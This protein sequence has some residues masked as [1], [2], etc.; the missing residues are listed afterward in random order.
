[1]RSLPN[2]REPVI[3]VA[4]A[5][6]AGIG[7]AISA[8]AAGAR[9][10][11]IEPHGAPG[12]MSHAAN[13]HTICGLY[14]P[15]RKEKPEFANT[16]VPVEMTSRLLDN[17]AALPPVSMGGLWVL[18]IRPA[19]FSA[20]AMDWLAGHAGLDCLWRTRVIG[21]MC[22]DGRIEALHLR[23]A[24]GVE[25]ELPVSVVVDATGDAHVTAFAG[26]AT[27]C[28][29]SE[30]LQRP[31]FVVGFEGME[32]G[33]MA[34]DG[35]LRLAALL[36]EGVREGA[37]PS[38]ALG[39]AFRAG[40]EPG[41]IWCTIDLSGDDESGPWD[42]LRAGALDRLAAGG[43]AL[44]ATM[45]GFLSDRLGT[46][47]TARHWPIQPGVRES[48]CL[49]GRV[50]LTGRDV[51]EGNQFADAVAEIA[52]PMELRET[53]RGPVLKFPLEGRSA[54]IPG[55]ALRSRD[56][57]N[58][59]AAGRCLSCDHDAQAAIRVIGMGLATGQ[60][61]GRAAARLAEHPDE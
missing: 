22:R 20:V 53:T 23:G 33:W 58:L 5:G 29:P 17:G 4:G 55:G 37:L 44:A 42:P 10:V 41:L 51:L 2:I 27:L 57:G 49:H 36:V 9:V 19:G 46:G 43:R 54:T 26:A 32:N 12:G 14:R 47:I 3:A 48:R 45:L 38:A 40:A 24:D 52:W 8:S 16:G 15:H 61:A 31:A 56:L 39:A 35:K 7:A 50:V 59:F 11:L 13:V 28:T 6:A 25:T 34:P 60:A 1:M 18:P 30:K 21:A